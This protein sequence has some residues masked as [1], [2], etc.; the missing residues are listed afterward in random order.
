VHAAYGLPDEK[1]LRAGIQL[2]AAQ[3]AAA[4]A[5]DAERMELAGDERHAFTKRLHEPGGINEA[6]EKKMVRG[7]NLADAVLLLG[8]L[9]AQKRER[10]APLRV[11]IEVQGEADG[12][13]AVSLPE[14]DGVAAEAAVAHAVGDLQA[15][16]HGKVFVFYANHIRAAFR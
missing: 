8:L 10:G 15:E 3:R 13:P 9:V 5:P 2:A 11:G 14:R 4:V 7:L 12:F 1:R 6:D 16:L